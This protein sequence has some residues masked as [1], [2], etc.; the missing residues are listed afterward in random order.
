MCNA[1]FFY[2]L[3]PICLKRANNSAV[4][5]FEIH[6][7][8]MQNAEIYKMSLMKLKIV[9]CYCFSNKENKLHSLLVMKKLET[10]YTVYNLI[11]RKQHQQL[12]D[13]AKKY[14]FIIHRHNTAEIM[15]LFFKDM[16]SLWKYGGFFNHILLLHQKRTAAETVWWCDSDNEDLTAVRNHWSFLST[17][18]VTAIMLS[19]FCFISLNRHSLYGSSPHITH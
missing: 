12:Y 2:W 1:C 16:N 9:F 13:M 17:L 10:F 5:P 11:W 3:F 14:G 6:S 7:I 8:T 18:S 4:A 15:L 19:Y